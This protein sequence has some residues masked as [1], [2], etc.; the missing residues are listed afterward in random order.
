[1]AYSI[2]PIKNVFAKVVIPADKSISHRAL[3]LAALSNQNVKIKHFLFSEDTQA[4]LQCLKKMGVQIKENK[5]QVTVKGQGMFFPAKGKVKIFANQSG[6]TMRILSGVLSAQ[7]FPVVFN[8][9]KELCARPMARIIKPLQMMGALIDGDKRKG[10][11]YP[12]LKISPVK[13]LKGIKYTLP[14]ASAQVKSAV[15]LAGL[16]AE[17]KTTV[18]QP[19]ACRDHSERMLK[20]FAVPI[21]K[22]GK[23]ISLCPVKKLISP[24]GLVIPG[25]FSSAAFFIVLGLI[26]KG[27]K[28]TLK[29]VNINPTRCGL[30]KVLKR[31]GAQIEVINKKDYFEPFA[32]IIVKS[33]SLIAT[34][35]LPEEIPLMVD[36]I[37][38]LSVAA[39]FAKGKTMID[40]VEE[41]K[42]KETDRISSIVEN[43][44]LVG[45]KVKAY[46]IKIKGKKDWRIEIENKDNF[47]KA[48][49]KS[50]GDHRTAMS[51]VVLGKALSFSTKIDDVKCINKSFPEFVS[52]IERL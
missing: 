27:S 23:K 24:K 43:L 45:V 41:L 8:A 42:V 15:L 12:P 25:D 21:K 40:G 49:F 4:T 13:Q 52:L 17:G 22:E 19:Q 48:V 33:S 46:Q 11:L 34:K 36:E 51:L 50:F 5:D 47:K 39:C 10:N 6:T 16:Y 18:I 37:P 26:L 1:M 30:L 9:A 2:T 7:K 14:I 28:I 32:D 29:N 35:V 3:I 38:I 44:R 31:M 20:L